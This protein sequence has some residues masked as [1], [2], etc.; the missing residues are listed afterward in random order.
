MK[1]EFIIT[2]QAE[3]DI[4]QA[5]LY[6]ENQQVTLGKKISFSIRKLF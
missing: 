1:Y 4:L 3:Q 5:A 2:E 6:Y